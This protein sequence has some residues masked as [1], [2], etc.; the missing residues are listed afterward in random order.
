[1]NARR[2][3]STLL[4]TVVAIAGLALAACSSTPASSS[5]ASAQAS[6]GGGGSLAASTAPTATP[7]PS[8]GTVSVDLVFSGTK[9]LT[10]KG[11]A[12]QCSIGHNPAD[13]SVVFGFIAREADYPG[14]G[15]G[16]TMSEN[17]DPSRAHRLTLVWLSVVAPSR[18]DLAEGQGVTYSSDH[19]SITIDADI[20]RTDTPEHLSGTIS[21]P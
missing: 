10:A 8:K 19:K 9:S 17:L 14:L 11:K 18:A 16:L 3:Q 2:Q 4:V 5:A 6:V 7:A 12:G 1:L 13:G 20:G 15:D 21:C